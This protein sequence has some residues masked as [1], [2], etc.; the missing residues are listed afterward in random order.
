VETI[1]SMPHLLSTA[2][3]DLVF[4]GLLTTGV[5]HKLAFLRVNPFSYEL[6][7]TFQVAIGRIGR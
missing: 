3:S 7:D 2:A 6:G 4:A 5:Q 1:N